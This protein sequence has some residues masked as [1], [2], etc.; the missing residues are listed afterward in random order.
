MS[1]KNYM[2][3]TKEIQRSMLAFFI[4]LDLVLVRS[5]NYKSRPL[6]YLGTH[7]LLDYQV[8]PGIRS[9]PSFQGIPQ[10]LSLPEYQGNHGL[11]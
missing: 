6:Y 4:F 9:R 11:L 2:I 10:Y 7:H 5:K 1:K 8:S 3:N